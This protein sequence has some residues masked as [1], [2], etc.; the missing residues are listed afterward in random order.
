MIL[1]LTL[2]QTDENRL[3]DDKCLLLGS[4]GKGTCIHKTTTPLEFN[5]FFKIPHLFVGEMFTAMGSLATNTTSTFNDDVH[6][7][8]NLKNSATLRR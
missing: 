5:L 3:S 8:V 2:G 1:F 6:V 4:W 7:S